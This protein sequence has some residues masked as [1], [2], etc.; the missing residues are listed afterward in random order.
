[1]YPAPW[2]ETVRRSHYQK[3]SGRLLPQKG[4]DGMPY[5]APNLLIVP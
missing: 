2:R 4:S 3:R 5:R 1:M